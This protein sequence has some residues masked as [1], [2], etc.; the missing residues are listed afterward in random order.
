M[1]TSP[2]E[3]MDRLIDE[4]NEEKEPRPTTSPE[5]AE[6]LA[7]A[8]AVRQLRRPAAPSETLTRSLPSSLPQKTRARPRFYPAVAA[9]SI[10]LLLTLTFSNLFSQRDAVYAL[11]KAIAEL[12]N[13]HGV[14]AVQAQNAA[15][16]EWA[17]RHSEIWSEDDRY[18]VRQDDGTLTV[19]NGERKW[20]IRPADKEITLLPVAPDP[21]R[22]GFDLRA[23]AERALSY[24]HKIAGQETVA[25]RAA[26]KLTISP[27]G[28]L[29]YELWIDM[30]TNLPLQLRTAMLKSLQT[31]YTY[32]EFTPNTDIDPTVFAYSVPE[33]YAVVENGTGQLVA[34]LPEAEAIS[35]LA[36]VCPAG[37]PDRIY[38][39]PGRIVL[40][41]GDTVITETPAEAEF[42]PAHHGSLGSAAGGPL[43]IL[44]SRLRWQQAGLLIQVE[45]PRKE[46][47]ALQ[48]APDLTLPDPIADL[49]AGMQITVPVDMDVVRGSQQQVDGGSSPWQLDPVYVAQVFANLQLNPDGISG[50]PPLPEASFRLTASSGTA[51]VVG[52]ADGP[53]A[54]VY[55]K[56]LVRTD[57]TGIWTVVGYDPR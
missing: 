35:G 41:Y 45:G 13:Y 49:T 10:L 11:E 24:P 38:A 32:S 21:G 56:R 12:Q 53:V 9:A 20:Q 39:L 1:K 6:L 26:T 27:P 57:E 16:E 28:G 7:V 30:E 43:E 37:A 29:P 15:G 3:E 25:G 36:A 8:R 17:V 51:A 34:A 44:S 40:D 22:H 19:N 23:E 14:L 18:A 31:T 42:T 5:T 4:L 55:L 50:E 2:E 47:L 33:G 52:V 46:E 54:K 48:I